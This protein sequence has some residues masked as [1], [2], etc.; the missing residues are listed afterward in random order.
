MAILQRAGPASFVRA[1]RMEGLGKGIRRSF[2]SDRLHSDVF[3]P[4]KH[5]VDRRPTMRDIDGARN[6]F[7]ETQT[8]LGQKVRA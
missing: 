3:A 5:V 8:A 2:A 4:S 6:R 1:V 7:A